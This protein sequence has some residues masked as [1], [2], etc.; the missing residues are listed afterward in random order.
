[1]TAEEKKA[2]N[3]KWYYD[4]RERQLEKSRKQYAENREII[5]EKSRQRHSDN[6]EKERERKR[7]YRAENPEKVRDRDRRYRVENQD[8]I[9]D[10]QR[11]F[12]AENPEKVRVYWR[13]YRAENP[14]KVRV[15]RRK[16]RAENPEKIRVLGSNYRV[17]FGRSHFSRAKKRGNHAEQFRRKSIFERDGWKCQ[18]CQKK[19]T[20]NTAI[21]EHKI[22]IAKGGSHTPANCTTS[23]A[24]C[25]GEKAAK[26]LNGM[27][28]TIFD[29]VKD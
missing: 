1:M 25:N 27:Q 24:K 28:I 16:Y 11:R 29:N 21:L 2:Y 12:C 3:L 17:E 18:Y 5:L 15:Y 19:V 14:E 13:K 22:P 4:N 6:P 10:S 7:K 9:R 20:I 26:L 8:K 23:C